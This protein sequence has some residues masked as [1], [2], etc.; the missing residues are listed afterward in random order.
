MSGAKFATRSRVCGV[1]ALIES[2][3]LFVYCLALAVAALN[4]SG[5]TE[6][7]PIVEILIYLIFGIGIF[8]ISRGMLARSVNARAPYFVTQIFVLIVAYTLLVGDGTPVQV[9]GA[10]VAALG[11]AGFGFGVAMV[12]ADTDSRTP[13]PGPDDV[14][15]DDEASA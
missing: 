1:I 12:S 9:V 11:I 13:R 10:A 7:A 2:V 4:S 14:R 8:F 5:A 3:A 6:S 15:T